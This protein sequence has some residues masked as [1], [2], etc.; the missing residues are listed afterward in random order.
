MCV[1]L[2]ALLAA[3]L[4]A[5][6]VPPPEARAELLTTALS[7]DRVLIESNFTGA[8]IV[9]FGQIGR[10]A[11]TVT[12]SGA[13][14]LAVVVRGP[15]QV[16]T[17]RR[18]E[19]FLGLWVNREAETFYAVPSFYVLSS[20]RTP[21]EMGARRMLE[22]YGIGIN[23][24]NLPISPQSDVPLSERDDF[25]DAFLRLRRQHGDYLE[26]TG[27]VEFLSETLF[28]TTVALP[29]TTP[30]G[31]YTVETF[32]MNGGAMLASQQKSLTVAKTGFEQMAFDL[33]HERPTLYGILA[34]VI[35]IFTGWLAGVIFR[36]D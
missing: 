17:T 23:Y 8:E 10:D 33:A 31:E 7:S 16:V 15:D 34:V 11:Q 30:V 27:K 29:A 9:V 2:A 4:A 20:T 25:R 5:A 24:L 6:L 22:K 1:R 14:D 36:K 28:R 13:Y 26:Q 32:L 12:R 19:R 21:T 3:G 18:K 35:A